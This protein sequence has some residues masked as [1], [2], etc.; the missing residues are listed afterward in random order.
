MRSL[1]LYQ[2]I[3]HTDMNIRLDMVI[4]VKVTVLK[5]TPVDK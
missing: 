1:R 5:L 2:E 4:I 3:T